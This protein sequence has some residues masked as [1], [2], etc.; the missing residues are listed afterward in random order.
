M[1]KTVVSTNLQLKDLYERFE[2]PF[3][4]LLWRACEKLPCGFVRPHTVR[5]G[6]LVFVG[7]G[8]TGN[9][10]NSRTVF[11]YDLATFSW[12]A[13]EITPCHSF[14]LAIIND[15]VTIIGG[16]NV[17]TS[18]ETNNLYSY[19]KFDTTGKWCTSLPPMLKI[20]SCH[21][22]VNVNNSFVIVAGGV[23]SVSRTHRDSVE[24]FDI[25]NRRWIEAPSLPIGTSFMCMAAS[26]KSVFLCG[27]LGVSGAV[28]DVITSDI[29]TLVEAA[30]SG[31]RDTNVW[32]RPTKLP[33]VRSGCVVVQNKLVTFGGI[34][35][36]GQNNDKCNSSIYCWNQENNTWTKLGSLP[37]SFSSMSGITVTPNKVMLFGGYTNARSWTTS[38]SHEALEVVNILM[39]Q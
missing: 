7:G 16:V 25:E 21:S 28:C 22:V 32:K 1:E 2:I 15:M 6:S 12:S 23:D 8:Y 38:L 30:K 36:G 27:G 37:F 35:H 10:Q 3:G 19:K 31:V 33:L 29:Q 18:Q 4:T 17:M 24:I 34:P 14:G 9:S 26:N 5:N 39:D 13:L 20:R 11:Q